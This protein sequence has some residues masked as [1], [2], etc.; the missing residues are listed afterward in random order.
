MDSF[1]CQF[2]Q[3]TVG[4]AC[5]VW[6]MELSQTHGLCMSC[7]AA[8]LL[9]VFVPAGIALAVPS[10]AISAAYVGSLILRSVPAAGIASKAAAVAASSAP[11]S[12][13]LKFVADAL[14]AA[15]AGTG[16]LWWL[17][18]ASAAALAVA[19]CWLY[20]KVHRGLKAWEQE[21]VFFRDYDLRY[22]DH[23]PPERP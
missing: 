7:V 2:W 20:F 19:A 10:L 14:S 4:S 21:N 15:A 12:G 22:P 3:M 1:C 17:M 18:P 23:T 9:L 11:V 16:P 8:G 6:Q 13:G 5:W